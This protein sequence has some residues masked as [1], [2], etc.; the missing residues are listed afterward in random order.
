MLR[1]LRAAG[2]ALLGWVVG[3]AGAWAQVPQPPEIAARAYLLIDVT[4]QQVLAEM[5][6]DKPVE[7]A[8]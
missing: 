8:S 1:V 7:P 2:V 6:A 3:A 5:D 4:A